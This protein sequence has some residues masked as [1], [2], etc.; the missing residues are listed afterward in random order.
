MDRRKFLKISMIAPVVAFAP[1]LVAGQFKNISE[2]ST[3]I[4]AEKIARSGKIREIID[5][6]I[7]T[8]LNLYRY[9]ISDGKMQLT[10]SLPKPENQVFEKEIEKTRKTAF[11]YL[12]EAMKKHRIRYIDLINLEIP[13]GYKGNI[14]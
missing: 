1:N 12:D 8:D 5:Y 14:L 2:K 4:R 9:D 10:I 3:K 7:A 11:K 13:P 6:D